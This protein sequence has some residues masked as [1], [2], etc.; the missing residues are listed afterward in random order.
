[1]EE[2][3]VMMVGLNAARVRQALGVLAAQARSGDRTLKLPADYDAPNVSQKIV[4]III[5]YVDYVK[6]VTWREQSAPTPGS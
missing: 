5:S 2:A 1:M 6:S 3:A 4:R